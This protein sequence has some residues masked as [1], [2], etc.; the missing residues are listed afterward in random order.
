MTALVATLLSS[1]AHAQLLQTVQATAQQPVLRGL[2]V[3]GNTLQKG[4]TRLTLDTAGGYLYGVQIETASAADLARAMAG[5]W[6]MEES[7]VGRLAASLSKPDVM[8]QARAG[9]QDFSDESK[10]D[11]F[12]LKLVGSGKTQ[13][14]KA[15]MAVQIWPDSAFPATG[16]AVGAANAPATLRLFSDFQCPYCQQLAEETLP[17]WKKNSA[18]YRVLHYHF[19]LSFH[20]NAFPAAEAAECAAQQGKFWPYTDQLFAGLASWQRLTGTAT[21][22][23]FEEYGKGVGLNMGSFRQCVSSHA[24]KNTVQA[25]MDAGVRVGVGGTPTVFLNGVHLRDY[26]D[27]SER[28]AVMAITAAAAR[29]QATIQARLRALR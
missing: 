13:L 19:P 26:T 2:A 14:W 29:A 4:S 15:Y 11:L 3:Q 25:Q 8:A 28:Q 17:D 10:S 23:K 18:H 16:N 20:K 6:G 1:A 5:V 21:T 27:P 7:G 9:I 24:T 12:A 22:A